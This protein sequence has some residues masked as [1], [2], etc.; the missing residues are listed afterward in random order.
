MKNKKCIL[1]FTLIITFLL[2]L[3]TNVQATNDNPLNIMNI[4]TSNNTT[5]DTNNTN[6]TTNTNVTTNNTE[7]TAPILTTNNVENNSN[8]A[9]TTLPQTGIAEDTALFVFIA[10]CIVSAIYAFIKVRNYKN[11]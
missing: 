6:N 2:V 7:N 9:N 4:N 8:T 10:V 5:A 11:I 1:V 3:I